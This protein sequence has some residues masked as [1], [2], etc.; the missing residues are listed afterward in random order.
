M[1]TCRAILISAVHAPLRRPAITVM[2]IIGTTIT[3]T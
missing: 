1:Y 2:G 3:V